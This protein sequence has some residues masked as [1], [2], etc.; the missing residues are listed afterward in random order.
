[1]R[2]NPT[3][4]AVANSLHD[5]FS[6]P[7]FR[8]DWTPA[9]SV[10]QFMTSQVPVDFYEDDQNY[11]VRAELPGVNKEELKVELDKDL[12]T[13][14]FARK[15]ESEKGAQEQ[16]LRR[17]IRVPEDIVA[18]GIRAGMQDGILT[19]TLPKGEAMKPRVISVN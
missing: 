15:E 18:E 12:L 5:L 13:F 16:T 10:N 11:Y 3:P 9:R 14:T 4:L 1:M 6:D 17:S 8:F 19:L 7:F 2:L